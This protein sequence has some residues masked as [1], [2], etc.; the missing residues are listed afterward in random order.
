MTGGHFKTLKSIQGLCICGRLMFPEPGAM[1]NGG[2]ELNQLRAV[3]RLGSYCSCSSH[4]IEKQR[5]QQGISRRAPRVWDARDAKTRASASLAHVALTRLS[6][7]HPTATT[8]TVLIAFVTVARLFS[9]FGASSNKFSETKDQ[10]PICSSYIKSV[11]I[12]FLA[13]SIISN[14]IILCHSIT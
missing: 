4:S 9:P 3:E 2:G 13:M 11:N 1:L 8:P 5:R 12:S 10:R 7:F 14:R 6:N